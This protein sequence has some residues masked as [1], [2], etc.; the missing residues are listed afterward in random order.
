MSVA[1]R[2]LQS[3]TCYK[4]EKAYK[5]FTLFTPQAGNPS[6]TWLIDMQGWFVHRWKLQG[7][8]RLQA[9]LLP[10]GNLFFGIHN[11]ESSFSD[12][13]ISGGSIIEMDWDGN[14][15]WRYDEPLMDCHDRIRRKNGNT[16]IA[17]YVQVPKEISDKVKGGIPGTERNGVMW[18]YI[19]QEINREGKV[20]WETVTYD[21]L[22]PEL[23]AFTPLAWRHLWP[24]WNSLTELPNGDIMTSSYSTSL[25]HI[26]DKATGEVKWRWGRG[27]ISFPHNPS[28]LDNG[29]IL[30]LDNG[31]WREDFWPPDYSRVIE[32]NPNTGE[33]EWEFK[34]DNPVD[35]FTTYIGGCERLPNGNTLICEGQNGRFF[36][37]TPRGEMVWEYVVPFYESYPAGGQGYDLGLSNL[38]FRAHRYG[39]DYP[40]LQGKKLDTG[41]LELINR[42]YGPGACGPW[43]KQNWR[44]I[45]A[46]YVEEEK[47][48]PAEGAIPQPKHKE[49]KPSFGQPG[50]KGKKV[51]SR[52]KRL[53]Y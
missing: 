27:K 30:L 34:A 6:N 18:G 24:G 40:G 48:E 5:G 35:F 3:V 52:I 45:E 49:A 17:K 4:P 33:I 12:L 13:V 1:R 47:E 53:G 19:L 44:G 38:T 9:V 10:N 7:W 37:I 31:R 39:A 32:I 16:I 29:N 22:D 2:S 14:I 20:V 8:V 11:P 21:H 51:A 15:V 46:A 25:I 42:L 23:D 28:V 41:E 36:E 43:A 26:I 50:E